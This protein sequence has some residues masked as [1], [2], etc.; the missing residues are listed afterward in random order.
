MFQVGITELK[1]QKIW[2]YN[3]FVIYDLPMGKFRDKGIPVDNVSNYESG[4]AD[5]IYAASQKSLNLCRLLLSLPGIS[6]PL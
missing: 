5:I 2:T 3:R 4:K 1:S 6:E